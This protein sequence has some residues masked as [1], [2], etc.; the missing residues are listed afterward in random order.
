MYRL[1]IILYLFCIIG[2]SSVS[3]EVRETIGNTSAFTKKFVKGITTKK[4]VVSFFGYAP[5]PI[6]SKEWV[7]VI[8]DRTT[9]SKVIDFFGGE[10]VSKLTGIDFGKSQGYCIGLFFD[11]EGYLQD[12]KIY[13]EIE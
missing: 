2:C 3:P 1:I 7:Y 13:W 11:E 6:N 12:Y 4:D 8:T 5:G 10:I 9:S